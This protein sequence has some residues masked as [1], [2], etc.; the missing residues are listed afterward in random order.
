MGDIRL[1]PFS[2]VFQC[3]GGILW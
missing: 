3:L 2:G 1:L